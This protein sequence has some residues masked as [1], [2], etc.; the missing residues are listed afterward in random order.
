[1]VWIGT[2]NCHHSHAAFGG[3]QQFW[4]HHMVVFPRT[5]V[6]IKM[7]GHEAIIGSPNLA[8]FYNHK[9]LYE[10]QRLQDARDRCDFFQFCPTLLHEILALYD[11]KSQDRW[12]TPFNFTHAFVSRDNFICQ[13]QLVDAILRRERVDM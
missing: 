3:Q 13:R 1:M 12:L 2:F 5:S 10:R 11:P 7:I 8:I 6:Q 4:R 9:T